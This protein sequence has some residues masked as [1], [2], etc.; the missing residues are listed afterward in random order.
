MVKNGFYSKQTFTIEM[1]VNT[2]PNEDN[3]SDELVVITEE[4]NMDKPRLVLTGDTAQEFKVALQYFIEKG[5]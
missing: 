3:R 1:F 5:V 2:M 4:Y